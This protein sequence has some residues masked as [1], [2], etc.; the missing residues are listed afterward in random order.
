MNNQRQRKKHTGKTLVDSEMVIH[1]IRITLSS[2][3]VKSWEKVCA[4]LVRGSKEKNLKAKGPVW[5]LIKTLRITVRKAS[6]GEGS[7][8]QVRFQMRIHKRLID[9]HSCSEMGR[10][11]SEIVKQMTSISIE[12]E[13]E[14]EVTNVDASIN[15]LINSL[16]IIHQCARRFPGGLCV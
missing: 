3:N 14:A 13:V 5:M 4:D 1:Q 7:K 9:L 6:V 2:C 11:P 16:S 8:I 15:L 12:S 10:P